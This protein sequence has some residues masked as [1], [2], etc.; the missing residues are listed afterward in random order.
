MTL[1]EAVVWIAVFI[2]AML[3]LSTSVLYFYRTSNYT[4]QQAFA[5][6]SAQRGI[7]RRR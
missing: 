6:A 3:A 2:S 4:I 7:D 1:I 5:T